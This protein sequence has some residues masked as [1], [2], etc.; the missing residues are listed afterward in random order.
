MA[1]KGLVHKGNMR[2][3]LVW[4][5]IVLISVYILFGSMELWIKILV[6]IVLIFGG[7]EASASL[8]NKPSPMNLIRQS[9]EEAHKSQG[10]FFNLD[11]NKSVKDIQPFSRSKRF[12]RKR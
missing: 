9:V 4:L 6:I 10:E 7:F 3:L 11:M 12:R 5:I 1:L 2:E 8:N